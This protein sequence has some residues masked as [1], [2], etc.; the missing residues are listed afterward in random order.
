MERT[1]ESQEGAPR[2]LSWRTRIWGPTA[3][4]KQTKQAAPPGL[5]GA[6]SERRDPDVVGC[7][8]ARNGGPWRGSGVFEGWLR[9]ACGG[10]LEEENL[11]SY[12]K[13]G[14]ANG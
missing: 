4:L 2:G 5:P 14:E 6:D 12:S 13:A 3:H 8:H 1:G 10:F 7:L 9:L 11:R